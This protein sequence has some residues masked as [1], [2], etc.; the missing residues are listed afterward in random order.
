MDIILVLVYVFS[1]AFYVAGHLVILHSKSTKVENSF[2]DNAQLCAH[3]R[4]TKR[5]IFCGTHFLFPSNEQ[6]VC[7]MGWK[8][9]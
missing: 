9:K 7:G 4:T 2:I 3:D 8:K 5:D 1:N 6:E